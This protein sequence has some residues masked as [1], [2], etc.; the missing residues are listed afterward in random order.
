METHIMAKRMFSLE[1]PLE[2]YERLREAAQR[3]Q[4]SMGFLVRT[5][6]EAHLVPSATHF[7]STARSTTGELVSHAD[8]HLS[9]ATTPVERRDHQA[10]RV[11]RA[12]T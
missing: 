5:A 11:R 1:L 3:E 7:L 9:V 6:I 8:A 4:R 2:L 10:R 12:P